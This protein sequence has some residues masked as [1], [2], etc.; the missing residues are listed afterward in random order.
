MSP[1]GKGIQANR[2]FCGDVFR[3]IAGTQLQGEHLSLLPEGNHQCG[4][5]CA[6]DAVPGE[7]DG[8]TAP[9]WS[10][11]SSGAPGA[12][13]WGRLF[14][15]NERAGHEFRYQASSSANA[16][17]YKASGLAAPSAVEVA[18]HL[19]LSDG[20]MRRLMT[21]LL[22]EKTLIRMGTEELYIHRT[23]LEGL[24][25]QIRELHGQALD[26]ARFKKITGLPRKYAI[27][28]LEHLDRERITRKNGG[29]R[30]VL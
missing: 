13:G 9:T 18:S 14:S 22:R 15:R 20:E 17:A 5:P 2:G 12:T 8:S 19:K 23:A 21:L 4:S 16:D 27:P 6:S 10:D 3:T 25:A 7:R 26:V 30:V 11:R 29:R 1:Q 24:R 28:L